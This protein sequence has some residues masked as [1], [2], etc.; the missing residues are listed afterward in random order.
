M[1]LITE[2][3][4]NVDS[5][6]TTHFRNA[7]VVANGSQYADLQMA[8]GSQAPA[9]PHKCFISAIR[10]LSIQNL[11]WR[12][13]IWDRTLPQ[14][15][16]SSLNNHGLVY[17]QYF[18]KVAAASQYGTVFAYIQTGLK[19]P[20]IDRQGQG[21]LHVNLVNADGATAKLAGDTGA[22]HV[23]VGVIYSS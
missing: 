19:V 17:S 16:G 10:V 3:I 15:T 12:V 21:Q 22:V 23:R 5:D 4:H 14:A 9:G 11:D 20:Y 8:Q 18:N 7:L 13:E 6:Y 1:A 2:S